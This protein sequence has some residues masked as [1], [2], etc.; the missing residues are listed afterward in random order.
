M[1]QCR[2][3]HAGPLV[4]AGCRWIRRL[5]RRTDRAGV[6]RRAPR[7]PP[8]LRPRPGAGRLPAV[9]GRE[10]RDRTS[11]PGRLLLRL[12]PAFSHQGGR[13]AHDRGRDAEDRGSRPAVHPG[14][15]D[16]G[17]GPRPA[18]GPTVQAGD[19]RGDRHRRG[20]GV[21]RRDRLPIPERRLGRPVRGAARTVDRP[22]R[23]VQAD[24]HRGCLLA[25]RR[26][27]SDAHPDLRDRVGDRRGARI[28]PAAA[29]GGR[30]ARPPPAR[31]GAG[32]V[33]Q[34]GR[35][36]AR[37]VDLAPARRHLP[38]GARGLGPRSAP[39]RAATTWSSRRTS[40]ALCCG[41]RAATSRST[42]RTCIRRWRR[43]PATT[44]SSR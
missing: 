7:P 23:R 38:E 11:D 19:H 13:P 39:R 27:Q 36:R 29:G 26:D 15:G 18:R 17:G 10:V 34:P 22:P 40:P 6:R 21:G 32:S 20:R 37:S 33:L 1:A 30:E 12:R 14:R 41:R 43:T 8:L 4:R 35:A 5:D 2:R 16:P 9:P 25:R 31:A 42:R 24:F 28:A 44:T 3:G